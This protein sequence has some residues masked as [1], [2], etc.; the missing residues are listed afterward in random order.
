V[1]VLRDLA[2]AAINRRDYAIS[3]LE[4]AGKA[5]VKATEDAEK[6]VTGQPMPEHV[7]KEVAQAAGYAVGL[8]MGQLSQTGSFLWD[9][10]NGDVDPQSIKD[11]YTGIQNGRISP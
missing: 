2:S 9:V 5:V 6:V 10:Y 4:S 3:P 11:R 8:P 1:P 7:G